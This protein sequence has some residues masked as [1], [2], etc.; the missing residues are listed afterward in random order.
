[1]KIPAFTIGVRLKCSFFLMI[2]LTLIVGA[3]ALEQERILGGLTSRMYHHPLTVGN[4]VRDIRNNINLMQQLM[5][6][7]MFIP[8]SMEL[9]QIEIK[10]NDLETETI[11]K[12]EIVRDRF[13]GD[14]SEVDRPLRAFNEWKK[15]RDEVFSRARSEGKEKTDKSFYLAHQRYVD[16]LMGKTQGLIDFSGGKARSFLESSNAEQNAARKIMMVLLGGA[17]LFGL[18]ISVFIT[19]TITPPL[20]LIV[21]RMKDIAA[22]DFRA[23]VEIF[24]NDEIGELADSFREMQSG[25]RNKAEV[26]AGIAEGD[27]SQEAAVNGRDDLLGNAINRMTL[28]LRDYKRKNDLQDWLKT[29]KNE[30]N[31]VIVGNDDLHG[32]ASKIIGFLADYLNAR[33]GSFFVATDQGMLTLFGSYAFNLRKSLSD[34]ISPG[35]GLLGQAVLEKQIISITDIPEGYIR[36]NSSFGDSPP[37]NIVAVPFLYEGRVKGVIELGSF[38]EFSAVK[39]DFLRDAADFIAIAVHTVQN[40]AK[41]RELLQ[42]T[43]RQAGELRVQ[44]EELRAAN[45]ELGE[46][47]RSLKDSQEELKQQ[48]EELQV[49]NEELE[50]KNEFLEKQKDQITQKNEALEDAGTELERRSRELEVSSKYK[51]EFLANMSHELRTPLNSLL[52]LSRDLA[53]N[54]K[55]NLDAEQVESARIIQGSGKELLELINEILDL[56]KIEAGRMTLRIEETPLEDIASSIERIFKRTAEGKGIGFEVL[57]DDNLQ[58]SVDTDA[59][60]LEQILRNLVSNALKFTHE[61]MVTVRLHRAAPATNLSRSGLDYRRTIGFSVRDTGIGIAEE[62]QSLV[63]EAFQ[64]ADGG[65][66][67]K[68]GGT[69]LGL[70]IS[71]ELAKILGGEIQL[72]SRLDEGATFTLYLPLSLRESSDK[73]KAAVDTPVDS[74]YHL[75]DVSPLNPPSTSGV[76]ETLPS[77]PDDRDNLFEGDKSILI[78]EDDEN[79]ARIL[80]KECHAKGFKALVSPTGEAGL[81]LAQEVL[82]SAVILDIKLPGMNGWTVLNALKA[83]PSTRHIP[84]HIISGQE[85]SMDALQTGAIGFLMKPVNRE[86]MEDAFQRIEDVVEKKIKDLLIVEDNPAQRLGIKN[87]ISDPEVQIIEAE[88]GVEAL[89]ALRERLFD[90]MILDLGLPDMTGFELLHRM[91][92]EKGVRVPPVIVYTGKDLT[93]EE[94]A[95]LRK[96]SETII[97]KGVQS[98]VRLLDEVTLFLH[99]MVSTMPRGKREMIIDLHDKNAM[100]ADKTVLLVDDDMRNLFALSKILAKEGL[101]VLKAEDGKKALTLLEENPGVH[102]VLLD[103]MMPVMDGYETAAEIRKQ[104]RFSQLPIIALTAKAMKD[105]RDKCI[106]AGASDYLSK[107]VDTDR[108]FSMMRVWLYKRSGI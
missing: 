13:L 104:R 61:G 92:N 80:L 5:L 41:L 75:K 36:I 54:S 102:L 55:G 53:E 63:F 89:A 88:T 93:R 39:L 46:Q 27:F 65:T 68:Y 72:T 91:E 26:A 1:M 18:G 25:L 2:L 16:E 100:F 79:F 101:T 87:L 78:I 57:I 49:I 85:P 32:L 34:A 48:Q 10:V 77:I 19:R 60:R 45:E 20:R 108:L 35:E 42:E 84:V 90:C 74:P 6:R 43:Q 52:L 96:H 37:R 8:D 40:Q 62:K 76:I 14:K 97:I 3:V 86:D 99:K 22:G 103:M 24:Q 66:S 7:V 107:P 73:A 12:F 59:Q 23:G 33:I 9:N 94:E 71:R 29:G 95:D 28:T 81:A 17:L 70:S 64:Q 38:E 58:K 51:S 11:G 21:R 98:E 50:E 15:L 105:D 56:S 30:L 31:S 106:A 44:E 83:T 82:P 67:R 69:G 4:T 47:T